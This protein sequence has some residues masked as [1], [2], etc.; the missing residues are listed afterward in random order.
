MENPIIKKIKTFKK[1]KLGRVILDELNNEVRGIMYMQIWRQANDKL[2]S[3][4]YYQRPDTIWE[5]VNE[6]VLNSE[7]IIARLWR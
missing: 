5:Q 4:R 6:Q 2:F 7:F 3:Q 1:M